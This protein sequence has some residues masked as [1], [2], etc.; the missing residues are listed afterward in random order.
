MLRHGI[1]HP[2]KLKLID[3]HVINSAL[4]DRIMKQLYFAHDNN[5][6]LFMNFFKC[7]RMSGKSLQNIGLQNYKIN[8]KTHNCIN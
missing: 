7:P 6:W 3:F 1:E 4:D 5:Y 8:Q 2:V